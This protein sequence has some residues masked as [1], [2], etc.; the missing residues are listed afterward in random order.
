VQVNKKKSKDVLESSRVSVT[1]PSEH[2]AK[3]QNIA[4]RNKV[5]V[6]WVVRDAVELYLSSGEEEEAES[7][8]QRGKNQK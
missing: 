8:V 3:L 4:K 5:S 2:Y 1:F 7:K 6:A